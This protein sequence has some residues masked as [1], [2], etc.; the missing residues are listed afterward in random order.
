MTTVIELP[1]HL[2]H[3][4]RREAN[5]GL[6]V[7]FINADL[8]NRCNLDVRTSVVLY[9]DAGLFEYAMNTMPDA[10]LLQRLW[11]ETPIRYWSRGI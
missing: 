10:A 1:E 8:L 6:M 4:M 11:D 9:D 5:E 3:A 7:L 2:R